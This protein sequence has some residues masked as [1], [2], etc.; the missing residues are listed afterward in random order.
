MKRI[1]SL[2]EK[3]RR[4]AYGGLRAIILYGK[5]DIGLNKNKKIP[6]YIK[7]TMSDLTECGLSYDTYFFSWGNITPNVELVLTNESK[8]KIKK[9]REK[10]IK[11]LPTTNIPVRTVLELKNN[12]KIRKS[13][14]FSFKKYFE[15]LKGQ[16]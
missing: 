13:Q 5:I 14:F 12:G 11:K 7:N 16:K 4:G 3:K 6:A 8:K 9:I 1:E 15:A 2:L 10:I